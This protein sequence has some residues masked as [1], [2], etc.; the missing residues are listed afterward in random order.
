[1]FDKASGKLLG[2]IPLPD[3]PHGNPI[4]YQHD[5]RQYLVVSVG[6]GPF[7]AVTPEDLGAE[8]GSDAAKAILAS[9]PKETHPE[10]VAFRLP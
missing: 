1:V 7:F 8:A 6:G 3:T 9:Q 5:G 2:H 10:L 4:T